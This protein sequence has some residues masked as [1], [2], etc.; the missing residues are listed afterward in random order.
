MPLQ[1]YSKNIPETGKLPL[2]FDSTAELQTSKILDTIKCTDKSD[3]S[4]A[5]YIPSDYQPGKRW[6]IVYIFDPGARGKVPIQLMYEAAERYGYILAA[7]NNSRNGQLN[8]QIKAAQSMFEDTHL[9]LSINDS[10][11]YFAGFSGGA[12]VAAYLAGECN[13]AQGVLL[14][15]A[16]FSPA[17]APSHERNQFAVFAI[18]GLTDFNYDEMFLLNRTLDTLNYMHFLRRFDG[19][20]QW[21]P[22]EVWQEGFA[23]MRLIAIKNGRQPRNEQLISNEL[24]ASMHRAKAQQDSGNIYYAWLDYRNALNIFQGLADIKQIEEQIALL[25]KNVG[26]IEGREEEEREIDEQITMQNKVLYFI[27][28]MNTPKP[29][30]LKGEQLNNYVESGFTFRELKSQAKDA[31]RRLQ[32]KIENEDNVERR[33]VLERAWNVIS[34]FLMETAQFDMDSDDLQIAK[35]LFEL[36]I[37]AQPNTFWPHFSLARCLINIGDKDE[38]IEELSLARKF[39]LSAQSL[40]NMSKQYSELNSLI[41]NPEFQKLLSDKQ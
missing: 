28:L 5:L 19:T 21:A 13:C 2:T 29:K 20:H 27:Q 35:N 6:P 41:N 33:H 38:S 14:N 22:K 3:Q 18:A 15:S 9:R 30:W 17:S 34:S 24:A 39:G 7:S 40:A 1:I 16:G 31:I 37:E 23:W 4:Y 32:N 26:V 25:D 36:A 10:C 8:L 11:L 12:R